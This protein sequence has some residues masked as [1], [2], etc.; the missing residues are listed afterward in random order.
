MKDLEELARK[1]LSEE[2]YS[3]RD[4][5]NYA[6]LG[7]SKASGACNQVISDVSFAGH[8]YNSERKKS[9]AEHLGEILFHWHVLVLTT[10]I[11]AEDIMAQYVHSYKTL[12]KIK[13]EEK[14]NIAELLR[15]VKPSVR[16]LER[17]DDE[18]KKKKWREKI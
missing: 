11:S 6:G 14:V 5:L 10:D 15:H 16:E 3:V 9:M 17:K 4:A 1:F 12:H 8:S 18:L 2:E 7:L 13:V